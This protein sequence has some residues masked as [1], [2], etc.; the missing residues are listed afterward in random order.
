MYWRSESPG[1]SILL[2]VI[3]H[4]LWDTFFVICFVSWRFD[5]GIE[6]RLS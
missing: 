1:A 6:S 4:Y 3:P 5:I 2:M